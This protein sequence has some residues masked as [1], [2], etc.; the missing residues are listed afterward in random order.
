MKNPEGKEKCILKPIR[1]NKSVRQGCRIQNQYTKNQFNLY[2]VKI[3][4][5]KMNLRK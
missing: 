5:A 4:N 3:N 1:T 2:T